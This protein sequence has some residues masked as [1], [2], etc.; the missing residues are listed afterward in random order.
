[1]LL[2]AR[3]R[4]IKLRKDLA[5]TGGDVREAHHKQQQ[6]GVLKQQ[7]ETFEQEKKKLM[8]R[9]SEIY[10]HPIFT[11]NTYIKGIDITAGE[12]FKFKEIYAM[13]DIQQVGYLGRKQFAHLLEILKIETNDEILAS[14][15]EEMDE[16]D[17]VSVLCALF[18]L[19]TSPSA[20]A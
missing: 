8:S 16:N 2:Q 20:F 3:T 10:S 19:F 7:I 6:Y 12:V 18:L 13:A 9:N 5:E 15:F 4:G 14:M 11:T 17:D 1:M